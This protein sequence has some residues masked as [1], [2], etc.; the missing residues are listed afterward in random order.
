M[1]GK[2][3][4][5]DF[6]RIVEAFDK[7]PDAQTPEQI[8]A[9]Y[10]NAFGIL[11]NQHATFHFIHDFVNFKYL[12]VSKS[13]KTL[14]GIDPNILIEG[15]FEAGLEYFHPDD[16]SG[17]GIIHEEMFR[18]LYQQ[19]VEDRKKMRFDFNYRVRT[20]KGEYKCFMQQTMFTVFSEGKPV[21]DFS[22]CT[23]ITLQRR[24]HQLELMVHKLNEEGVFETVY[25]F[26][27]ADNKSF[28]LSKTEMD[29]LRYAARGLSSKE[30]ASK[31][32][33]SLHTIN[34][35]RKS[36]LAKT[37]CKSLH[38]AILKLDF[39]GQEA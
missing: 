16:R 31:V 3:E 25:Y 13:L 6:K 17:I 20:A 36:I 5:S 9:L 11:D 24:R 15:G 4:F 12:Y 7:V 22:A 30:I 1:K 18:Y 38:E 23:D 10:K 32:S 14:T 26:T 34:N 2:Y 21:Y 29:I 28:D 33:R 35:H 37:K 39:I 19:P 27:I 8:L